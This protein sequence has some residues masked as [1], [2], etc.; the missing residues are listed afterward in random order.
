MHA[1]SCLVIQLEFEHHATTHTINQLK[2]RTPDNLQ[3]NSL[4]NDQREIHSSL[5]PELILNLI[6]CE[7]LK[8]RKQNKMPG[9]TKEF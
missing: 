9:S 3:L 5:S 2:I 8:N 6:N 4:R 7:K 1:W